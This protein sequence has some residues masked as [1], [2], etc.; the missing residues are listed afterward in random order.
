V[1]ALYDLFLDERIGGGWTTLRERMARW[2]QSAGRLTTS[3]AAAPPA[4]ANGS[5][6]ARAAPVRQSA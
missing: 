5:D 1:L 2:A 6:P 3:S 4:M